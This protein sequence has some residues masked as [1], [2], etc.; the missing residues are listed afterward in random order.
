[1]DSEIMRAVRAGFRAGY[2]RGYA[3]CRDGVAFT[4]GSE[5]A[6]SAFLAEVEAAREVPLG[7]DDLCVVCFE[8]LGD[9]VPA[10]VFVSAGSGIQ[11]R[12]RGVRAHVNCAASHGNTLTM[13][14]L[15]AAL[16]RLRSQM[17]G[18]TS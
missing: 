2:R 9:T 17:G 1:M 10:Y 13:S 4:V 3:D 12:A 16:E 6:L 5:A 15:A 11:R 14:E 18:S 8:P 7:P